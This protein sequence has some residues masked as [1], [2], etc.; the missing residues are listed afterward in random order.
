MVALY[1]DEKVKSIISQQ[2]D[3]WHYYTGSRLNMYWL[4]YG[5]YYFPDLP[6]QHLVTGVTCEP[7]VYFDA[8][9]FVTEIAKIQKKIKFKYKGQIGILISNYKKRKL[10]LEES[11]FINLA[12]LLRK[13]D[14]RLQEF[15]VYLIEACKENNNIYDFVYKLQIKKHLYG[16]RDINFSDLIATA[17]G[18]FE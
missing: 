7:S 18:I 14:Q 1:T 9:I 4:G 6:G 12:P 10:H 5:A 3:F 2:Y 16:I 15:A 13:K 8:N 11:A 17:L